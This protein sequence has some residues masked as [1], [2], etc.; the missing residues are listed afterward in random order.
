MAGDDGEDGA[1]GAADDVGAEE[2]DDGGHEEADAG[3][4]E[5]AE[6]AA[7]AQLQQRAPSYHL[8]TPLAS[9]G[10]IRLPG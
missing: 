7:E 6:D 2:R 3:A 8:R 5:G 9:S 10:R 4:G 1:G